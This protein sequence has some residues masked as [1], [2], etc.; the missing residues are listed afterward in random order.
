[1]YFTNAYFPPQLTTEIASVSKI[2]RNFVA[3]SKMVEQLREMEYKI[4]TAEKLLAKDRAAPLGDAP[5]LLAVHYCLSELET[6][7]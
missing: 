3:T 5:N 7:R 6:F 4:E 2:Y 1:M